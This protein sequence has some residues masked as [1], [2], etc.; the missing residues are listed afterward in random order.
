MSVVYSRMSTDELKRLR[1]QKY[2]RLG[3]ILHISSWFCMQERRK[4]ETQMRQI[5]AELERRKL[6]M[7]LL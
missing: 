1:S 2:V 3:S 5:D 7:P 6:Q 4:L